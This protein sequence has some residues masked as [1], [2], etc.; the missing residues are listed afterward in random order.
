[1]KRLNN[2]FSE[3]V[4][5]NLLISP[6]NN[7]SA[8]RIKGVR[9]VS[10]MLQEADDSA[11]FFLTINT[12]SRPVS[13]R[14][15]DSINLRVPYNPFNIMEKAPLVCATPSYSFRSGRAAKGGRNRTACYV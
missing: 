12:Q 15:N 11:N 8:L 10:F 2:V 3:R 4:F 7:V 13:R 1:M 5:C 9:L 6:R 14:T